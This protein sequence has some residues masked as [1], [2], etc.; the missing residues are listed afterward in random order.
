MCVGVEDQMS[1]IMLWHCQPP[2]KQKVVRIEPQGIKGIGQKMENMGGDVGH[3]TSASSAMASLSAYEDTL[4]LKTISLSNLPKFK[5]SSS[6]TTRPRPDL[7]SPLT[8][9][10]ASSSH[11]VHPQTLNEEESACEGGS[12]FPY[13]GVCGGG[14]TKPSWWA[15]LFAARRPAGSGMAEQKGTRSGRRERMCIVERW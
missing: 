8:T 5:P 15:F 4:T 2:T 13:G 12:A 14:R 3:C 1:R 7:I 10:L 11:D 9:A 6:T